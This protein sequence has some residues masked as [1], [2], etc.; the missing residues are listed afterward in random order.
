MEI[1]REV[2]SFFRELLLQ[3]L[4]SLDVAAP[5]PTAHYLVD[6]LSSFADVEHGSDFHVPF[7]VSLTQAYSMRG[8]ER[9]TRMRG[10]G[11]S[12]L[13]LAGFLADSMERLGVTRSYCITIGQRAYNEAGR[14]TFDLGPQ[15]GV[16]LDLAQRFAAFVR[17]LDEV[18]EQT[19]SRTHGELL[20]L[21]ERWVVSGSP[22]LL[23]RLAQY[24][25]AVTRGHKGDAC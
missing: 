18:R 16:L 12:A 1:Y 9:A 17:V 10:I 5:E 2:R 11:D 24:G 25:V 22:E 15:P 3:A 14:Q 7:V 21:Y 13:F 8:I 23:R 6:L 4:S 20:R 19:S